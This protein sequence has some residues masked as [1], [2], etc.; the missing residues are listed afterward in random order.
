[1]LR[2]T[3]GQK[4]SLTKSQPGLFWQLRSSFCLSAE[5]LLRER[6]IWPK[7][8]ATHR[9][10]ERA[11][12]LVHQNLVLVSS[13]AAG[14]YFLHERHLYFCSTISTQHVCKSLLHAGSLLPIVIKQ[15]YGLCRWP[16]VWNSTNT[17][18]K[19]VCHL[20]KSLSCPC[21]EVD[22]TNIQKLAEVLHYL[23]V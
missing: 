20:K 14:K 6:E 2:R 8:V 1:M 11:N 10:G 13:G 3:A 18:W 4:C 17:T 15:Q 23:S 16:W 22:V 21:F 9:S 12:Y 19:H 7:T 5:V